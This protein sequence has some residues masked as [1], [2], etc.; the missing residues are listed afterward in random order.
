MENKNK[1]N[2]INLYVNDGL[3]YMGTLKSGEYKNSQ[4]ITIEGINSNH[5][6]IINLMYGKIYN[7]KIAFSIAET[8]ELTV[9]DKSN[10]NYY[11]IKAYNL[12][13]YFNVVKYEVEK[14]PKK[15]ISGELE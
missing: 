14:K 9:Y 13:K 15:E 12:P 2:Y 3:K 11:K 10:E 4:Y 8:S 6:L 1:I 5:S 7:G